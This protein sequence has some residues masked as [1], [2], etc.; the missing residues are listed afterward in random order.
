M[1]HR[2]KNET[3]IET[4]INS[5]ISLNI[6][7][8]IT[9]LNSLFNQNVLDI[10]R[11]LI[12]NKKEQFYLREL[13]RKSNVPATTC[14][15]IMEKLTGVG[16]VKLI[17]IKKTK[18][19]QIASNDNVTF[20]ENFVRQDKQILDEFIKEVTKDPN[21]KFIIQHGKISKDK[22]DLLLIGK[23]VNTS[24]VKLLCSKIKDKYNFTIST[25]ALEREQYEQMVSMG[26]YGTDEK[27]VYER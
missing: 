1:V 7:D 4:L 14:L 23:E 17:K 9:L 19:Y 24:N 10:L 12:E 20:I 27:L 26:L 11:T 21:I 13:A 25:L 3:L 8:K 22:A 2:S 6:M 18:L 15:R 5:N 16:L